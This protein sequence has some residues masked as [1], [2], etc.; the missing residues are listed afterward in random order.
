M[1]LI[2][3]LAGLK[4]ALSPISNAS[5]NC[6]VNCFTSLLIFIFYMVAIHL[7][8]IAIGVGS[9]LIATVVLHG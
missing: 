6:D 8:S 9:E 3:F 7:S 5:V 4:L 2:E 1:F